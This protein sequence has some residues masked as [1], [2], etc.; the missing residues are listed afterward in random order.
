M[1]NKPV[2][3][4][5]DTL[6]ILIIGGGKI[7]YRKALA[8][9]DKCASL[10]IL[11]PDLCIEFAEL[12]QN[13]KIHHIAMTFEAYILE[14]HSHFMTMH[15]IYASTNQPEVNH[16][17]SETCEQYGKLINRTDDFKS[18]SFSDMMT[19]VE[20]AFTIAVS[21]KGSPWGSKLLIE[22][23]ASAISPLLKEKL[24]FLK[25]YRK[26]LI[27]EGLTYQAI[28]TMT[29]EE[30]ERKL[31]MKTI[32]VG[33]RGS[34]L[35][36]AQTDWV[37]ASLRA[38]DHRLNFETVIISTKG[39]E[40]QNISLDK[41]GDKGLFVKEI[42]QQ[43]LDGHID[44]AVHSMKDMPS[45]QG[46]PLAFSKTPK[47][48]DPRDILA[49]KE[50]YLTLDDL[51]QGARIGTG[52]KRRLFQLLKHRPDIVAV[53]IRGNVETR[54]SKI[55][56]ENLDGVILAAAGL[57]RLDLSHRITQ[58]LEPSLMIPAPAQGALALQYHKDRD[59]LRDLLNQLS[60]DDSECCI[61]AERAFLKGVNGSCHIPI[62]AYATLSEDKS[63]LELACIWGT[64]DGSILKQV[65]LSGPS[66]APEAL[67]QKC[68][69]AMKED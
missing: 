55:E 1:N 24:Y 9:V 35:A 57:H 3:I 34:R 68:A 60:D 63:T 28:K 38:L 4:H 16:M 33:T 50:G 39:D 43:L 2:L 62:G 49:L 19:H 37:I 11:S 20:N 47:R 42:E 61:R 36:R 13:H 27:A 30:L 15:L 10:T 26:N 8:F 5:T 32:K 53:P 44:I 59:D 23:V 46:L 18:G 48:E 40:I 14:H 54:L 58:Y 52:S 12:V 64:E 51:P 29:I 6:N 41:I 56:K 67:G 7:G 25:K 69:D 17:I 31:E 66:E 22:Q 65:R 21:S 45:D